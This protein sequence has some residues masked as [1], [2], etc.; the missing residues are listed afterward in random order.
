MFYHGFGK[1]EILGNFLRFLKVY[2]F[3][4]YKSWREVIGVDVIYSILLREFGYLTSVLK[5]SS[6]PYSLRYAPL[7]LVHPKMFFSCFVFMKYSF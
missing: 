7:I 4:I 1:N 2:L 3:I 5:S 6:I